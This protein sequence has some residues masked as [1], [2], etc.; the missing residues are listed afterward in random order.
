MKAGRRSLVVLV[1]VALL[2]LPPLAEAQAPTVSRGLL[3]GSLP[4]DSTGG[5]LRGAVTSGTSTG[6][7]RGPVQSGTT[8]GLLSGGAP[9]AGGTVGGF[10]GLVPVGT[11]WGPTRVELPPGTPVGAYPA[12]APSGA[13]LGDPGPL[14]RAGAVENQ[15]RIHL[16][17]GAYGDAEARLR[18]SVSIHEQVSG[19]DSP[20]V[21]QALESNA[22]LLREWNREAAATE[23]ETRIEEIRVRQELK[24]NPVPNAA[25]A[26]LGSP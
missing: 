9:P 1:G 6:L 25:P 22:A 14:D 20:E 3:R 2:G 15:A 7:L 26:P 12:P 13:R 4:S 17:K 16:I 10:R 19:P 23:M 8:G 21:V 18:Q 5:L 11:P 24:S